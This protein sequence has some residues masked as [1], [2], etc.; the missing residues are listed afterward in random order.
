MRRNDFDIFIKALK[1]RTKGSVHQGQS[2]CDIHGRDESPH[3]ACPPD[4]VFLP[5][6]VEDAASAVALCAEFG[7]PIVPFG[8]G[9]GQEGG[10]IAVQ[11]GLSINTSALN[12]VLEVNSEDMDCLVEAGVTRLQLETELRATGLFFPVDPGADASIGG[13]VA[14]GASGTT[15]PLYGSMRD[16]VMGLEV[17]LADGTIIQTGGRAPKSSAGYNLTQLFVASE[18]TLGLVT[19]VRLKLHPQPEARIALKARFETLEAAVGVVTTLRASG[20]PVAR[21]ELMNATL[22][23]GICLIHGGTPDNRH[24]LCLEF[25]AD[26]VRAKGLVELAAEIVRDFRGKDIEAVSRAE[27]LSKI[28][29]E[30]HSV[31]EAEKRLKPGTTVIVTDV[32]VPVSGLPNIIEEAEAELSRTALLAPLSGHV[33]DGNIHYALLVDPDDPEEMSRANGFRDWLARKALK[34]GGTISGEHGIGLGKR[35]LMPDAHGSA[36][37]VMKAIK[38]ALDPANIFNP[39]KVLPNDG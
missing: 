32:C 7:V 12:R 20:L 6:N 18:G 21:A 29:R 22:M 3:T 26:E 33:G 37:P 11:G 23:R 19:K 9:S 38:R 28:W 8:V 2:V 1:S 5:E 16:N 13:M 17:V 30:R 35:H 14:T 36:L 10:V 15:T 27:E 39:G 4:A 31:A 25:H 34:M 24:L